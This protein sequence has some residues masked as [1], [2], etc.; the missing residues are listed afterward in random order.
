M[1]DRALSPGCRDDTELASRSSDYQAADSLAAGALTP[2]HIVYTGPTRYLAESLDELPAKLKAALVR[3]SPAP[4][5]DRPECRELSLLADD[6]KKLEAAEELAVYAAEIIA[7]CIGP[8]RRVHNLSPASADFIL[9][10]EAEHYRARSLWRSARAPLAGKV[11][12]VTGAASGLGCGIAQGL[13]EAGAAVAFCDIDDRRRPGCG[14]ASAEPRRAFAVRMD[15]T[16]EDSVVV[17]IRPGRAP[18]GRRGH[19]GLRGRNCPALRIW[20]TSPSI[21]GGWTLEINLTGYFLV[22]REA[23]RIMRAQGDGRGDGHA[24]PPR[25]GWTPPKP[26]PPTTPPRPAN[27]T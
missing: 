4:R 13:V 2:D 16:D 14:C 3:K 7:P 1:R 12:V 19:S 6:P 25:A 27:C 18:L 11:A 24:Y 20:S 26:T 5:V 15:V 23:A 10:W 22:G 9:N 17:R 8:R 21:S